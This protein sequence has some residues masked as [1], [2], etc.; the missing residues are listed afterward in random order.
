M[1]K[2]F[3]TFIVAVVYLA[4]LFVLV[5]PNSQGPTLVKNVSDGLTG[6][7]KAGTGGGGFTATGQ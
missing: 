7:I 5:R 2:D 6:L 1:G 3:G 4:I